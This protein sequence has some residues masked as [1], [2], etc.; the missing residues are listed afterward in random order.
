MNKPMIGSYGPPSDDEVETPIVEAEKEIPNTP[1][2][3]V[4]AGIKEDL[5]SD[6][7]ELTENVEKVQSYKDVLEDHDITLD[8][9][10]SIVDD[11]LTQGFYEERVLITKSVFVVFRS[12]TH[13]DYRRYHT[14]LEVT[15]PKYKEEMN[16]IALRY[17]LAGS[18][19]RFR[20]HKFDHPDINK[21]T[22]EERG[23]AFDK[24]LDWIEQQPER[25]IAILAV[26]L[27]IFDL[28]IATV[29]SE[30][31]IENF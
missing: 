6:T 25:L 8:K 15:N 16:E 29:M 27:N 26:K 13:E 30:G 2:R 11:L 17:C 18:I 5:K 31:V 20:D 9:A 14:A 24:R 12:R 19:V 10:R 21:S 1:A 23:T 22:F 7:D 3:S 28:R 4:V